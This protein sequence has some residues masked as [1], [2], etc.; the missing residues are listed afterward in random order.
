MGDVTQT[1]AS[2]PERT[3]KAARPDWIDVKRALPWYLQNLQNGMAHCGR[4]AT[5]EE[6]VAEAERRGGVVEI[7]GFCV[8]FSETPR[9]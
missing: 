7:R 4:F 1:T 5:Q 8:C 9:L 6:A 3:M 2:Q